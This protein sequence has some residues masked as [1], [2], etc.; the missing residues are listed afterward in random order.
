MKSYADF[1]YIYDRLIDENYNRW[2]D[3]IE[4][5]FRRYSEKTSLVL[6]LAC[7][8]GTLTTILAKRGYDMIGLDISPDMLSIA[9]TKRGS[10]PIRYICNDMT[11][12]ELYGTVDAVICTL[13]GINYITDTKKL[14]KTFS[15]VKNYLNPGGLFVFDINSK[16]KISKILGN[17]CF[18]NEHGNIFYTWENI[19]SPKTGVCTY[20]LTF[21][22]QNGETYDR[23]D[24]LQK[25]R[26]YSQKSM[27]KMLSQSG[28][29]V[30]G[31]FDGLSFSPPDKKSERLMLVCKNIC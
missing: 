11:D 19:Y 16:Y 5:V 10:L 12:F 23:V 8:T 2:A 7:G 3:Y 30:L 29:T 13:D 9:E 18:V 22:V 14:K 26:A 17:N 24:E 1:A 6:D 4:E 25:Q 15:L 28:L 31:C 27:E 21:F 20:Q